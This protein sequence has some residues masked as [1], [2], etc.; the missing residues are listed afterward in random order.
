MNATKFSA[1]LLQ[2][3]AVL[4]LT[5]TAAAVPLY[6]DTGTTTTVTA[7]GRKN[8]TPPELKRNDVQL[9]NGKERLQVADWRREDT[10]R[11]AI[12][13]DES[14]DPTVANQWSDLKE[15]ILSQPPSTYIA[16]AYG[17]NGAAV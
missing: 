15:F 4:A 17:R 9:Y 3:F 5:A 10:L 7:V 16:V 12:L 13:I 8:S 14:L 2:A 1:R 6:A 11:L